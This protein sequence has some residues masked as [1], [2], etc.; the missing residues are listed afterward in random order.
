MGSALLDALPMA[1]AI[2]FFPV[3]IVAMVLIL[4]TDR[5]RISGPSFLLGW[6]GGL[7]AIGVVVLVLADSAGPTKAGSPADWISWLKLVL[8][9]LLLLLAWKQIRPAPHGTAKNNPAWMSRLDSLNAAQAGGLGAALAALNPKNLLLAVAGATEIAQNDLL[10]TQQA[11]SYA[12]FVACATLGIAIPLG[13]SI[14]LGARGGP[15][16]EKLKTWLTG[17]MAII[18]AILCVLIAVKLGSEAISDLTT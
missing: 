9:A 1:L 4:A 2:A 16:L 14:G 8:A 11:V 7:T 6:I 5:G 12:I 18:V 3:P 13:I 17:N 15:V 10:G